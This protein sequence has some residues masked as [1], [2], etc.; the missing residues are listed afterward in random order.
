MMLHRSEVRPGLVL[1]MDAAIL[2]EQ[3]A[4]AEG[5]GQPIDTPH[6]FICVSVESHRSSW[7]AV[8]S[9]NGPCRLPVVRKSGH[10]G[11][12]CR[13]TFAVPFHLWTAGFEVLVQAS[14]GLDLSLPG[15][16]NLA[17]LDWTPPM[18]VAD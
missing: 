11:W 16:R 15:L 1:F 6:Y 3:G 8:S 2:L 12:V 17:A 4:V 10:P 18:A 9:H 13:P 5:A 14:A 7:I